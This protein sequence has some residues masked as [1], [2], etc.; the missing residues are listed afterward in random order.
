MSKM[1]SMHQMACWPGF[2]E[3]CT[4]VTTRKGRVCDISRIMGTHVA[5]SASLRF[6]ATRPTKRT[7]SEKNEKDDLDRRD[8]M[9][10]ASTTAMA[11]GLVAGY[12]SFAALA[13]RFLYPSGPG[14]KEWLYVTEVATMKAGD[15]MS[16]VSPS[17]EKVTITR[18]A[19]KGDENDFVALSS[20]CPH[21]GC[22]VHW[23]AHNDRFFCPCHNGVFDTN[24]KATQGPPADAG[25]ELLQFN[26]RV[27]NGLLYIEVAVEALS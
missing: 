20:I 9:T 15:S 17:G 5:C 4:T 1:Q 16:Y 3:L 8:F 11:G 18:Q 19:E 14:R 27:E 26:T 21:L 25:Q 10:V 13:G 22:Q 23:E 7:M 24:G 2:Q 6:A 12:G